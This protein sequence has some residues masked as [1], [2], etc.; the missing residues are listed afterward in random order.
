MVYYRNRHDV[1]PADSDRREDRMLR[2]ISYPLI[3]V[4]SFENFY[5]VDMADEGRDAVRITEPFQL[6][7]NYAYL[8]KDRSGRNEYFLIDVVSIEMLSGFLTTLENTDARIVKE[9]LSWEAGTQRR[10]QARD[11]SNNNDYR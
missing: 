3:V 7:V 2:G 9:H 4:N 10:E 11:S 6:E 5:R 8:D 1:F